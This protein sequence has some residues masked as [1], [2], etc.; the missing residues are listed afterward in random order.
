MNVK[1]FNPAKGYLQ[2]K[3]EVDSEIQRV[4]TAGDLILRDDVEKFE[5]NLADYVGVKHAIGLNSGTDA[6]YLALRYLGIGQGDEVLVPAYTF[7]ATAQVV[8][9]LGAEPILYDLGQEPEPIEDK[10]KA[11][12]IAHMAGELNF[13]PETTCP[14]IED[15]CQALGAVRNPQTFAQC[16]SFYPAKI[17]GAYGDA[18]AITTNDEKLY[19]WIKEARNHFK[20]DGKEWGINSRMDNLQAAI[21]NVK[22]KYLPYTLMRRKEIAERYL[23]EL[24]DLDIILPNNEEGRVWQDFVF[25]VQSGTREILFN[26]LKEKGIECLKNN[27][28]FPIPKPYLTQRYEDNSIR[29]PCNENLDDSDVTFVIKNIREFYGE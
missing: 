5:K 12:M 27:Y 28:P 22:F 10:T 25:E 3:D 29:I 8:K 20:T 19:N 16:W 15:A 21:L 13:I 18:G 14:V 6:L 26:H 24:K 23:N 9:Q 2:I 17:L 11:I 1:F 7:V 4:L